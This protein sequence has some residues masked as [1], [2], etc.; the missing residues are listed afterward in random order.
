MR[1]TALGTW[2]LRKGAG[3]TQA[4]SLTVSRRRSAA[5]KAYCCKTCQF[6]IHGGEC[7]PF[8]R[9]AMLAAAIL[10]RTWRAS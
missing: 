3:S 6:V 10:K 4:H 2:N 5:A 8:C 7:S 9:T 1:P